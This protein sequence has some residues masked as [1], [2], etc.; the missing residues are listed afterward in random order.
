MSCCFNF[1]SSIF[2]PALLTGGLPCNRVRQQELSTADVRTQAVVEQRVQPKTTNKAADDVAYLARTCVSVEL[3]KATIG[4]FFTA[5]VRRLPVWQ[6]VAC[7][8]VKQLGGTLSTQPHNNQFKGTSLFA[9]VTV[10]Q[11]TQH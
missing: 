3:F 2:W 8:P 4:T 5:H 6:S 11:L 7:F 10:T 9:Y 1:P